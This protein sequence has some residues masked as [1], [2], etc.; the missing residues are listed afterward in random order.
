[1][2]VNIPTVTQDTAQSSVDSSPNRGAA[3]LAAAFAA[4]AFRSK[5]S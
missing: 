3:S 4:G 5:A 1:M 2:N